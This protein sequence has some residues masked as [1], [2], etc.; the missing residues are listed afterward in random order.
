MVF[1]LVKESLNKN[2]HVYFS[3]F[4]ISLKFIQDLE[5]AKTLSC[6]TV[7]VDRGEFPPDLK[8]SKLA[9]GESKHL[10][11]GN[12]LVVKWMD[13]KE[14]HVI[15][16]I[17][18]IDYENVRR[19][20]DDNEYQK[21]YMICQYNT[22]MSVV[23]K[24]DQYLSTYSLNK[25]SIKWWKKVF[26]RMLELAIID[27]MVIHFHQNENFVKS[28]RPHKIFRIILSYQLVQP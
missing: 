20:G 3:N 8:A 13:K 24:C 28:R 21:P 11:Q 7:R 22:F 25:P 18:G 16:S 14:V 1:E 27:A 19:R 9:R 2:H 15:S 17:Y 12:V 26:F 6:G 5:K 10:L 23:D 4:Y